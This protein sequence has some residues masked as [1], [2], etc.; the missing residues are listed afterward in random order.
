MSS[1]LGIAYIHPDRF[2]RNSCLKNE[3]QYETNSFSLTDLNEKKTKLSSS[4]GRA[5]GNV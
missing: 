4:N 2:T 3:M 1:Y 5:A